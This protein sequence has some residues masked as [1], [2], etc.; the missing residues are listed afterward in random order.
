MTDLAYIGTEA[1]TWGTS[2]NIT[3]STDTDDTTVPWTIEAN[4]TDFTFNQT[5]EFY[6]VPT[7]G[8]Y[9]QAGFV[10][11]NATAP[12]GAVTTGF[13]WFGTQVAYAANES[14]YEMMFWATATNTTGIYGLYVRSS[15]LFLLRMML[16]CSSGMLVVALR[17]GLSL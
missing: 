7:S 10:S 16:T 8:S 1:P 15:L 11:T 14:D 6:I 13:A 9:G 5:L 12:T 3:F 2:T 4:S 17:T